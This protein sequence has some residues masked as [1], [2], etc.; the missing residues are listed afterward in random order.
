M[1][2]LNDKL[3]PCITI[4]DLYLKHPSSYENQQALLKY[5]LHV[6]VGPITRAKFKKIKEALNGGA[7]HLGRVC[8]F[9]KQD[10]NIQNELERR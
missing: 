8:K 10:P 3:E 4:C 6:P 7:I 9:I 2:L 5:S 1:A